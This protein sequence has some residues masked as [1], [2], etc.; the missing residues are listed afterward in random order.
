M[1]CLDVGGNQW[2]VIIPLWQHRRVM[3]WQAWTCVYIGP[4]WRTLPAQD[5]VDFS[6]QSFPQVARPHGKL[7]ADD[8][9]LFP[10]SCGN[11]ENNTE[12]NPFM[13]I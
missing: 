7:S 6:R 8:R 3:R 2:P 12:T 5:F 9:N 10:L 13:Y 1:S 4:W 11:T